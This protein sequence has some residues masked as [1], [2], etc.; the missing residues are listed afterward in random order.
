[1]IKANKEYVEYK[2]EKITL[3]VELTEI[4]ITLIKDKILEDEELEYTLYLAKKHS[5]EEY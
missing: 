1:M 4:L 3:Q 2:G 5:K